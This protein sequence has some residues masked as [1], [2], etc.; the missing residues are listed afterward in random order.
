MFQRPKHICEAGQNRIEGS[1][2]G[3]PVGFWDRVPR[4][5]G[6][7]SP[8]SSCIQIISSPWRSEPTSTPIA[9]CSFSA[10]LDLKKLC[11]CIG[12]INVQDHP[13]QMR[14]THYVKHVPYLGGNIGVMELDKYESVSRSSLDEVIS[15]LLARTTDVDDRYLV[16]E[17]SLDRHACVLDREESS[18]R[19]VRPPWW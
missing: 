12:T 18:P 5:G 4:S 7:T 19:S 1:D 17:R 3:S 15:G 9:H 2:K 8:C 11:D 16:L 10:V 14:V 6:M 13:A